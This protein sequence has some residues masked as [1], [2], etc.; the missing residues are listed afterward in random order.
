MEKMSRIVEDSR[1]ESLIGLS[2]NFI[3]GGKHRAST[4]APS[5]R[6]FNDLLE[7]NHIFSVCEAHPSGYGI[8]EPGLQEGP[9]DIMKASALKAMSLDYT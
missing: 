1:E 8:G 6:L 9:S 4:Q 5:I 2:G 3:N 7:L